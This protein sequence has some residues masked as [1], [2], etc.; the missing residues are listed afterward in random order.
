MPAFIDLTGQRFGRLTVISR[1]A[2]EGKAVAWS[3]KCECGNETITTGTRLRAGRVK[4]CGCYSKEVTSIRS[5]IHHQS[6]K[7]LYN[8]WS[9]MKGRCY[10]I[11]NPHYKE[12]GGRG[13]KVCEEW[14]HDYQAFH[15]WAYANGY[16]DKAPKYECT[17]DRINNDG[18]YSPSNCRFVG[19][20]EQRHNR[21]DSRKDG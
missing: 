3:C 19:M 16:D 18:D 15:D 11:N 12:Y 1:T 10:N 6:H 21:R 7:R 9:N 5:T 14:R 2:N 20:T 13:I 8:V 4:S 17:I